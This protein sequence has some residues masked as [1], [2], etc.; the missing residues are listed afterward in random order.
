MLIS[1]N[2]FFVEYDDDH[3]YEYDDLAQVSE[4]QHGQLK[5]FLGYEF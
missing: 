5:A 4:L 3:D 1:I 2:N